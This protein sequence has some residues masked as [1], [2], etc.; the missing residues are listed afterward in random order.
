MIGGRVGWGGVRGLLLGLGAPASG[1]SAQKARIDTIALNLASAG[2]TAAPGEV[3]YRRKVVEL[4]PVPPGAAGRGVALPAATA[5]PVGFVPPGPRSWTGDRSIGPTS[6]W[7]PSR[8]RGGVRIAGVFEDASEGPLVYDPGH[9]HA[10]DQGYVRHAN[11][12]TTRELVDLLE[13][14][15]LFDANAAVFEAMKSVLRRS[16]DI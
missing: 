4:Q 2:T 7:D 9:P 16:L 12:D 5:R 3:P 15:R 11:V 8:D 14:R 13:A 6:G 1:I 10:D